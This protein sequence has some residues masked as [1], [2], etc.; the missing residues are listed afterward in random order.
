[1]DAFR[2]ALAAL[3]GN[4]EVCITFRSYR[5]NNEQN[6]DQAGSMSG[7]PFEANHQAAGNVGRRRMR[8]VRENNPDFASFMLGGTHIRDLPPRRDGT[9]DQLLI[10]LPWSYNDA[11]ERVYPVVYLCDGF[12]DFPLVWGMYSHLLCDKVVPEYILV[13]LSYGGI[14]ADVEKLRQ[15]DLQSLRNP[16]PGGPECDYMQIIKDR[17]VPF[18]EAEYAVDPSF[19]VIAGCSIGATFAIG[20]MLREPKYFGAVIALSPVQDPKD[21]WLERLDEDLVQ[22]NSRAVFGS[23]FSRPELPVRLFMG[24]GGA[25][26]KVILESAVGLQQR[27][28]RR[29]YRYFSHHLHIAPGEKHCA[30]KPEGF[31][32]GLRFAFDGRV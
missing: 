13:G 19:R 3:P 21:P 2:Q 14:D 31:N 8:L 25:D 20:A 6:R 7:S 11:P 4:A 15:I 23:L 9:Q 18:V 27:W 22:Q 24:V 5:T 16:C 12:W 28:L 30:I 32:R 1:M 10:S 29:K 17:I 26:E